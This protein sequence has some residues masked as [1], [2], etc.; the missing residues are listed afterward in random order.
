MIRRVEFRKLPFKKNQVF[1]T[2][3]TH[4]YHKSIARGTS[5]WKSGYRDFNNE[6]EMTEVIVNNINEIVKP[7]DLLIH[8]GDWS[9][10]G[11]DNILNFRNQINCRNIILMQGNHDRHIDDT[12]VQNGHFLEYCQVGYYDIEGVEIVSGHFPYSQWYHKSQGVLHAYGHVH[13]C[14]E[15]DDCSMDT[16]I[17]NAFKLVGKY[18]PFTFLEFE[19]F[20]SKKTNKKLDRKN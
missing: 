16:G 5:Q 4:A 20:T 14:W 11:V 6:V 7:T 2:S 8:N 9:F 17:D 3:D 13:G 10:G 18:R 12:Y 19:D 1:F 15:Q